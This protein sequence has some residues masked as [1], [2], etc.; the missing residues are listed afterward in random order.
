MISL[1]FY[2]IAGTVF[3]IGIV[4]IVICF[5]SGS[6]KQDGVT[7]SASMTVGKPREQVDQ[8]LAALVVNE[9]Q[10]RRGK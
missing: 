8:R 3:T 4:L 5:A 9:K 2:R 7:F 10:L 1:W 6:F